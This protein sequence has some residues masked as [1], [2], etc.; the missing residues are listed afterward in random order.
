MKD[1]KDFFTININCRLFVPT[2]KED[3]KYYRI[4]YNRNKSIGITS[5]CIVKRYRT[6]L[7]W[8]QLKRGVKD[9]IYLKLKESGVY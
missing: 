2:I 8:K 6:E 9:S 4:E 3:E 1:L 5:F 7:E